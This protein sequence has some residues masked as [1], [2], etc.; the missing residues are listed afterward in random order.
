MFCGAM[1]LSACG[2]FHKSDA[3]ANRAA[4]TKQAP[5]PT[6]AS[7][8]SARVAINGTEI[9]KMEFQSGISSATVEKLA[10][11]RSCFGGVGAGLVTP[12][13]P[14]EVYRMVCDN[15]QVFMARCELRQCK[16]M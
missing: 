16:A 10:K 15:G 5:L 4:Q 1:L 9:Q 8:G 14:I 2:V 3:N 12:P 6:R 7:D 11:A 13:G